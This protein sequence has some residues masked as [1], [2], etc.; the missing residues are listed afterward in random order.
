[1]DHRPIEYKGPYNQPKYDCPPIR[2]DSPQDHHEDIP[3]KPLNPRIIAVFLVVFVILIVAVIAVGNFHSPAQTPASDVPPGT[4]VQPIST[5]SSS[6]APTRTA[7]HRPATGTIISGYALL[8]G[9]GKL[10]IDNVLGE[11]DAVVIL[12]RTGSTYPLIGVYV[13][14]GENYT[15]ENIG[16]GS[17]NLFVLS[18][19]N[20]SSAAKK[21]NDNP[22][23]LMFLQPISYKTQTT[24]R[25]IYFEKMTETRYSTW[26]VT[27][28]GVTGGNAQTVGIPKN[29]FPGL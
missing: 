19:K 21:F 7:D 22:H 14:S 12:T 27:L 18:G 24:T 11:Q 25:T 13:G 5:P 4:P 10:F 8:Q 15:I 9:Y 28:Y 26:N 17:Y 3:K 2:A 29:N 6:T 1:V 20:W 23:Y 16:D